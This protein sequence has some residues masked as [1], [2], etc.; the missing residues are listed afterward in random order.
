MRL[1]PYVRSLGALRLPANELSWKRS[2]RSGDTLVAGII[3]RATRVSPLRPV[4]PRTKNH[5]P[6][7]G[8]PRDDNEDLA[9][10]LRI[11]ISP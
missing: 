1:A 3:N 8:V 5:A 6:L 7:V 9:S 2:G 10:S 11:F 4:H